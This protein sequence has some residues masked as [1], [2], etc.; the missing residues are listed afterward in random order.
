[1]RQAN[2]LAWV[3]ILCL[4]CAVGVQAQQ[5]GAASDLTSGAGAVGSAVPRLVRFNG[6]LQDATGKALAGPV[7]VTFELFREQSGGEPLWWETQGVEVDAQGRYSVL[8]GATQPGG[9]P[10]DLFTAGEAR[11]LGISVG[12]IEQPRV[13]LVSVPYAFK[14]GDADTLGGKPATAYVA[15]DQLKDQVQSEVKEQLANPTVG[16]RSLEAMVTNPGSTPQAIT[17]TGPST[18]TCTTTGT[19]V[20]VTQNGTGGI[21][22]RAVS[23]SSTSTTA[24]FDNMGGGKILSA[25]TTGYAEKFSVD[26]GG[27]VWA[28]GSILANSFAATSGVAI[29]GVAT[30]AS[31]GTF[32]VRGQSVSTSGV[33]VFGFSTAPTGLTYG[34]LG[35]ALSTAG[36]GLSGQAT[37]VTGNTIGI[38]AV[39]QSPTS[40]AAIIDNLGG[41]KILSGRTTGYVEK[42]SVDASGNVIAAGTMTG[43]RLISTIASGTAPLTVTSN[44]L[45]PNLNAD[46]LDGVHASAFQPLGAYATLGPNSFAGDQ[47][48]TGKVT[49]VGSDT[50]QNTAILH[51]TQNG[52]TPEGGIGSLRHHPAAIRG[53][54]TTQAGGAIGV[55]GTAQTNGAVGVAGVNSEGVGIVGLYVGSGLGAGTVGLCSPGSASCI[56][57]LGFS[58]TPQGN[59][60]EGRVGADP[61]DDEGITKFSVD[62]SGN[63]WAAGNLG[64]GTTTQTPGQK[65][66]VNGGVRLNTTTLRPTCDASIRGTLW[67]T[68]GGPGVADALYVCVKDVADAY[69]WEE[70][71]W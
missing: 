9:L 30:A 71:N 64:V 32:G 3:V 14:A 11:W 43:T 19:C 23:G 60:I 18:F 6:T 53:D 51:V 65:L 48:I 8:L 63:V 35:S 66:E 16:L 31:G 45:V 36:T 2:R 41:G 56:G 34:I 67:L 42:F 24:I 55:L 59:L 10:M 22:F 20:T 27:N 61:N 39:T 33:G 21:S 44:T 68:Q 46:L 37:A 1:M 58:S 54:A 12:K 7:D 17:E 13:L 4:I 38:R 70:V 47:S 15:S 25:R 57:L 62:T 50:T 26:S 5:S 28:G 49:A 40:T 69:A 29:Y 52:S